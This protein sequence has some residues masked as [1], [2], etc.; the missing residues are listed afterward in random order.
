MNN[1]KSTKRALI[2][3]ILSL[4]LCMSM[5]IGTTF[6][7][8]TDSVTSANN[9]IQAGNLDVD[10]YMWNGTEEANRVE[11]TNESAPIFGSA[12][13]LSAQNNNADT[14]WEPGKTQVAYLSIKN[15]GS[16]DLKYKVAIDVTNP[17]DGKELY[18]VMQYAITPDA[19]Y[20]VNAPA[21]TT[22]SDVVEGENISTTDVAL[23]AGQEHFFALSVHMKEDAGNEYMNGKVEFDISVLAG[24]LAS[25]LDAFN[26]SDYD[27]YAGYPGTGFAPAPEGNT[28]AV[29]IQITSKD[30]SKIGS[31]VVPK[32][33]VAEGATDLKV[34]VKPTDKPAN[35]TVATNEEAKAYDVTVEGLKEGNKTPVK[36]QLRIPEGLNS[37]FV[38]VYHYDRLIEGA[39]YNPNTGYITFETTSFSPFTVVYNVN[40]KYETP[41]VGDITLPTAVVEE[42][43]ITEEIEWGCYGQWS[44]TEGLDAELATAYKFKCPETFEEAKEQPYANWYCDF[45]VKL[46]KDLG[47]NEIFL[48]GNYGGFGWIGFHNGG[49]TLKAN[50]EIGLLESVTTNP[51]TYLDVVQ[52]VGEFICGVGDVDGALATKDATFTVMLRLT[53]PDDATQFKNVATITYNFA[54][55]ASTVQ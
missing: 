1:K 46:D 33:A 21:W 35:I 2:T 42:Y 28:T 37:N 48:G 25:E 31:V 49:V 13:S 22:G 24:Q 53:N 14:L 47:Q 7:W 38:K 34:H 30:G 36:V 27:Q 54:T 12:N 40:E 55:G 20:S 45:Y 4:A 26:N 5:L 10:L 19:K 51:W 18:K 8:F 44:P 32:A 41:D 50:E 39:Y 23:K 52:N 15:N 3:S 9:K 17:V 43:K 29:E 11:I 6:A 16:L